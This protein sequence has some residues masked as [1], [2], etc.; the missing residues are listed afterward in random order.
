MLLGELATGA[1]GTGSPDV[2]EPVPRPTVPSDP[3]KLPPDKDTV[4]IG[5]FIGQFF[6][7]IVGR[8]TGLATKCLS[9]KESSS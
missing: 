7:A 1:G 4:G 6:W 8:G 3:I 2:G 5:N 9:P